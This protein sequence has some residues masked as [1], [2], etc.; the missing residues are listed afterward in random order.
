MDDEIETSEVATTSTD[1]RCRSNTSNTVR[2]NP[3]ASSIRADR[4]FTTVVLLFAAIALTARR[5]ASDVMSVP[6]P[7]GRRE[8]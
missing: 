8:L 4:S 1:V 6:F 5:G 7:S 3:G 2:R